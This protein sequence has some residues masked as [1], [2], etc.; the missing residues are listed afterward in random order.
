MNYAALSEDYGQG[1]EYVLVPSVGVETQDVQQPKNPAT[2]KDILLHNFNESFDLVLGNY[3]RMEKEVI[4]EATKLKGIIN[5]KVVSWRYKGTESVLQQ[6]LSRTAVDIIVT[7]TITGTIMKSAKNDPALLNQEPEHIRVSLSEDETGKKHFSAALDM[8]IRYILD[9]RPDSQRCLGPLI[10]IYDENTSVCP[11]FRD[12]QLQANEYLL[13]ILHE[14]DYPRVA[15]DIIRA[16]YPEIVKDGSLPSGFVING[17][18]LAHRMGLTVGYISFAEKGCLGR[19]YFSPTEVNLIDRHGRLFSVTVKPDTVL[20]DQRTA[21]NPNIRNSTLVHECVHVYL[22]RTFFMLQL[23]TG[24]PF[25]TYTSRMVRGKRYAFSQNSPI[26][27]MELQA[28]KMPAYLIMETVS[29]KQY[30]ESLLEQI[31]DGHSMRALE[32]VMQELSKHYGVSKAMVKYRMIE[33]GYHEAEGIYNFIGNQPI[34]DYAC[35]GEWP[36]GVTFTI[37]PAEAVKLGEV[38]ETFD[39]LMRSG[40]YVY[41]EGHFCLNDKR[42]LETRK[43]RF[44]EAILSLTPEARRKINECCISFEVH[45]RYT[46]ADYQPGTCARKA[47]EPYMDR[48]LGRYRLKEEPGT[49]EYDLENRTFVDDAER[50]GQLMF[51]LPRDFFGAVETV[52]EQKNVSRERLALALN[53]DRKSLYS[54]IRANAPSLPHMVAIL[55]ALEVPYYISIG[56]IEANGPS[57]RNTQ[58]HHLYRQ[59]LLCSGSITVDRCNDMLQAAG[60]PKMFASERAP[61]SRMCS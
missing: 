42:Y 38:S 11:A 60:Y 19:A 22:D 26:Q 4:R 30:I 34:P 46:S 25:Q 51:E 24:R 49:A 10:Y 13:P 35:S 8:R 47:K 59:M 3:I 17:E 23:L 50:W 21:K 28:E 12:K 44:G 27:W 16:F 56:I 41:V 18:D 58:L 52:M 40:K 7:A 32:S 54:A 55:V 6:P 20:I 43:G 15:N 9:I 45:G 14:E 39:R 53:I 61:L 36:R 31:D 2:V 37:E 48:Y 29:T 1:P 5:P 57:F 33:L